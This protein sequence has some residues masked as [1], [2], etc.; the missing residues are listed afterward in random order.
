MPPRL[1]FILAHFFASIVKYIF[2]ASQTKWN[3]VYGE[4]MLTLLEI[5]IISVLKN[6]LW[7][8]WLAPSAVT[9]MQ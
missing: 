2:A 8:F 4:L 9:L 3:I 1:S 6:G 7:A 5:S